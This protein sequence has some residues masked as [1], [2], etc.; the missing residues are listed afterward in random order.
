[1]S[2]SCLVSS[3]LEFLRVWEY[4]GTSLPGVALD[5]IIDGFLLPVWVIWLGIALAKHPS[6]HSTGST[7]TARMALSMNGGAGCHGWGGV[8]SYFDD[9]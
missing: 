5:I 4:F 1:M 9:L 3:W 7:P 2:V 6:P 8:D